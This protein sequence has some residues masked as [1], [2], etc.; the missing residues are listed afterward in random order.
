M[1]SLREVV[2]LVQSAMEFAI[3][4][5]NNFITLSSDLIETL[6]AVYEICTGIVPTIIKELQKLPAEVVDGVKKAMSSWF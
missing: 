3:S 5:V 2:K 6:K 4:F 1:S